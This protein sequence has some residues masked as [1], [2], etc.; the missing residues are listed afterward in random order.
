MEDFFAKLSIMLVPA[1]LAITAHEVAHGLVADHF[2]DPTARLSGR[3]TLNPVKHLDLVGTITLLVFGFGWA[4]PVPVTF[5]NLRNP[6][7]D[8]ILVALGGPV[9]NLLLAS[10]CALGLHLLGGFAAGSRSIEAIL[11]MLGFGLYVNILLALFNLLPIPPL[12]GGRVLMGLIPP[13]QAYA[14]SRIEPFGF[15]IVIGLIYFTGL[16][17]T[18]IAPLVNF[19]LVIFAGKQ[20]VVVEE[21][22]RFL[23]G[24]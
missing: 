4:K 7:R 21:A 23:F 3:L 5:G 12:D 6:R 14:L 1:L 11:L 19:V 18:V 10:I 20:V 24:H 8:M 2:G 22:M 17:K 16:W 15:L 9:A 13:K